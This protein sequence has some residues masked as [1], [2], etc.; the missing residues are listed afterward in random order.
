MHRRCALLAVVAATAVVA[1]VFMRPRPGP[2]TFGLPPRP[3]VEFTLH[4]PDGVVLA[5]A[6][7][8]DRALRLTAGGF[9]GRAVDGRLH[10]GDASAALDGPAFDLGLLLAPLRRG[11]TRREAG[12]LVADGPP[13]TR[14]WVDRNGIVR[15]IE[16]DLADGSLLAVV[17]KG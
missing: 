4:G 10:V 15:R 8:D 3:Q 13:P 16:V 6:E 2:V 11:P 9:E 17:I 5:T 12:H 1:L 7:G 14:A